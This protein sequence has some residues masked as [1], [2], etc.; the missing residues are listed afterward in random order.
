MTNHRA[1]HKSNTM[2]Y[3]SG[4]PLVL[5]EFVLIIFSYMGS[6]FR[7]FFIL[8]REDNCEETTEEKW[9]WRTKAQLNS[10]LYDMMIFVMMSVLKNK[11]K[12]S[13]LHLCVS[14]SVIYNI[15]C[16]EKIYV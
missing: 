12:I 15:Y 6:G 4:L 7:E 10:T 5:I 9:E 16:D 11:N 1:S 2:N 3:I 13:D 14:Y 8:I